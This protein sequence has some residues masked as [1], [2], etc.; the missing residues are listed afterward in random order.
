MYVMQ[1]VGLAL[2]SLPDLFEHPDDV[3][4]AVNGL[5]NRLERPATYRAYRAAMAN[6][7]A[8]C[9]KQDRL[10]L[11]S[12]D[13]EMG[14]AYVDHLKSR[15]TPSTIAQ[16]VVCLR[17]ILKA[18]NAAGIAVSGLF[19]DVVLERRKTKWHA[20]SAPSRATIARLLAAASGANIRDAR[21]RAVVGMLYVTFVPLRSLRRM[22]IETFQRTRR[23]AELVLDIGFAES[24]PCPPILTKYLDEYIQV[25]G[26]RT[27]SKGFLFRTIAGASGHVTERPLSQPDLYRIVQRMAA[28]AQVSE[29]VSPRSIR[30]SGIIRYLRDF[31]NM[32]N[33]AQ[34]A[35]HA[36]TR[37]TVRYA[38]QGTKRKRNRIA[39]R[40]V[41]LQLEEDFID[42]L[43]GEFY[44]TE[45]YDDDY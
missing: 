44:D 38:D 39:Y 35:G 20:T 32:L 27:E 36:S 7:S 29:P 1:Q 23:G 42:D 9:I 45:T 28:S 41:D 25:A 12:L 24:V 30:A 26:I 11:G 2:D 31:N 14:R 8:W 18:C 5:L 17:R 6:F 15:V 43:E 40:R 16:R 10:E 13:A 21:D 37:T 33:A 3:R 22:R 34:Q 19:D 4:T